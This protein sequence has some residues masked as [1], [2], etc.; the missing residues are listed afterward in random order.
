MLVIAAIGVQAASLALTAMK[1]TTMNVHGKATSN[2]DGKMTSQS[3]Q[4]MTVAYQSSQQTGVRQGIIFVNDGNFM[5]CN[6]FG[7]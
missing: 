2:V 5:T 4:V 3:R 1:I 7:M 6:Y